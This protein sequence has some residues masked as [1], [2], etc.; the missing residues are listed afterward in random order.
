MSRPSKTLGAAAA[1][2]LAIAIARHFAGVSGCDATVTPGRATFPWC[3]G[4]VA[5]ASPRC[6]RWPVR[7]GRRVLDRLGVA[8]V[9]QGGPAFDYGLGFAAL[10]A[11]E[12][13]SPQAVL[14]A[15]AAR[16]R[17]DDADDVPDPGAV[18]EI[19]CPGTPPRAA[20]VARSHASYASEC[21]CAS[22]ASCLWSGDGGVL[23]TPGPKDLTFAAGTWGGAG[24]VPKPCT[25][26]AGFESMPG[27]CK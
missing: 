1:A 3:A 9:A 23:T 14:D 15:V 2:I 26:L 5:G 13:A 24:C 17:L 4:E 20:I 21:A 18:E 25:E 7:L 11:G 22:D 8:P 27:A 10:R 19:A 16:L 12:A 6:F